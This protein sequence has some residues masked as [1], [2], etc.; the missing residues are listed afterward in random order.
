MVED[1]YPWY[2][3]MYYADDHP[4]SPGEVALETIHKTEDSM[5][6]E[7]QAAHDNDDIDVVE[8]GTRH[9]IC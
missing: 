5:R 1:E 3:R 7:I 2:V 9:R 8:Y 6:E 4:M